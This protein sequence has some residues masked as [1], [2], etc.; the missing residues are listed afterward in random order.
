MDIADEVVAVVADGIADE[1]VAF[2]G[3]GGNDVDHVVKVTRGRFNFSEETDMALI[4]E[5]HLTESL[6]YP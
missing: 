5:V 2:V 1:A 6:C 3:E 4:A